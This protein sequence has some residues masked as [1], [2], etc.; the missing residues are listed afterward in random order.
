[1]MCK[2]FS[3]ISD[4]RRPFLSYIAGLEAGQGMLGWYLIFF[5]SF[6]CSTAQAAP[7]IEL[8]TEVLPPFTYQDKSGKGEG[9]TFE[10]VQEI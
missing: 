9:F 6:C 7:Q 5:L 3:Q 2:L 10:I 4:S 1:M 8:V